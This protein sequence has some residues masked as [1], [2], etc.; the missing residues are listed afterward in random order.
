[1]SLKEKDFIEIEFVGKTEEGNVF[2]SNIKEELKKLNPEAEAKPFVFSIG[3]DMFL[4]GVDE[5]LIG[6]DIG[7]HNIKLTPEKAFGK[8][9]AKLVNM[10]PLKVFHQQQINP[11]PGY[12]FNFDGRVGKVLTVSGGR[13]MV[14]FNNPLAGKDVIYDLKILRKIEDIKEKVKALNEFLFRQDFKSEIK[15]KK[16]ILEVEKGMSKFVEMFKEKYKV[17]LDLDLE[18][19][20]LPKPEKKDEKVEKKDENSEK[21]SENSEKVEKKA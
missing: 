19:K 13:V 12:A 7:K 8:R 18:V 11:V 9:D 2:D 14:D 4:K 16:L 5:Y 10:M 6:K 1:M 17:I 3:Q 20:E 15:E 21:K